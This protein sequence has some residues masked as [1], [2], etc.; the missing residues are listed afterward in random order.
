MSIK[1]NTF[2]VRQYQ[3]PDCD[4]CECLAGMVICESGD[5]VDWEYDDNGF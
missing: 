4:A 3:A 1:T 2:K 5:L